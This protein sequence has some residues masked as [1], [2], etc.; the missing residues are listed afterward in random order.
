M[1]TTKRDY[2]DVLGVGRN[3]TPEELKK[4]YRKLALEFHPDRNQGDKVAEERFKEIG[5]AYSVLSDPEKR[6]RYDMYGHATSGAPDMSGFGFDSA[7]DLFDMFFGGNRRGGRQAGSQPGVDLRLIVD[8][9]FEEAAFGATRTIEVP[10]SGTCTACSGSGAAPGTS[11]TQ[12]PDCGGSGQTRRVV[13]SIFGQMVQAAACPRC[14]GEGHIVSTPCPT[15]HGQGRV[16]ERKT[17][18]VTIPAGVDQD[19]QVCLRGEGEAGPRG[20]SNGDLFIGFR[21]SPHQHL[22]RRGTDIVYELPVTVPQATLGDSITIPTLDGDLQLDVP[23]GT[24][25][26]KVI[27]LAGRGVPHVR[28]GRRGDQLNVI[29]VVI[30]HH[31][32]AAERKLYEQLEGR[33]GQPAKVRKGFFE[34]LRGFFDPE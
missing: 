18:D 25:H 1:A 9:T 34:N 5:E 24:Q 8:V 12:C 10:R 14:R 2:Y 16:E 13:Q 27:K 22:V 30:P 31:L 23:P 29:R 33:S 21:V 32:S 17:L 4:Q 26:G 3:T 11:P 19:V 15:C 28:N 7:F 20:G 6:Q